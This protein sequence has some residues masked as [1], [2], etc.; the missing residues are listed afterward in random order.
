VKNISVHHIF[1]PHSLVS[2]GL[3]VFQFSC[4]SFTTFARLLGLDGN[5]CRAAELTE[6]ED[7]DMEE[8]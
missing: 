3:E 5:N 7:V 8:Y 4:V 2:A 6:Y 1:A